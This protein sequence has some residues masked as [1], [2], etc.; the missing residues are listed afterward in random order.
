MQAILSYDGLITPTLSAN[1]FATF[2]PAIV[3]LTKSITHLIVVIT[4]ER[5]LCT[6]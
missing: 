1:P 5:L 6:I 2:V 4:H 3:V